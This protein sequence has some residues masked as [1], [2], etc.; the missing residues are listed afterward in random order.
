[1]ARPGTCM[2]NSALVMVAVSLG[3]VLKNF[4]IVPQAAAFL[5]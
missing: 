2:Y 5:L 3:T 1:M 4:T